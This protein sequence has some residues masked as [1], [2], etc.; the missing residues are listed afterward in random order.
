[1]KKYKGIIPGLLACIVIAIV[2][3]ILGKFVPQLGASTFAIV[4]GVICGNTIIGGKR[5]T[6]GVKFSEKVLLAWAI[7]LLGVILNLNEII[8]IGY[9]GV[10]F[11]VIQM[12]LTIIVTYFIGK[13]LGFGK[14]FTLLMC[15]GNAVCGSSAIAATEGVI[16]ADPKD[17]GISVAIV[18]LT[19]T[20]LMFVLPGI[21]YLI[22][23]N[24]VMKSSA[25]IGGIL[26]SVGQVVA[27]G[28]MISPA[29]SE[30][31]T[32][33]KIIRIIFL[34]VV[35]LVLAKVN[36]GSDKKE[37][38]HEEENIKK[39]K[40]SVPWFIYLFFG[41]TLLYTFGFIPKWLGNGVHQIGDILEIIALA[42]IGASVKFKD[43]LEQGPKAII[44]GGL[45]G[46]SQII[47]AL[48]LIF[49]LL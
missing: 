38:K 36:S 33:F 34:V 37:L 9:K 28:K 22:Y 7:G 17:K 49:I 47:F 2:S 24:Q 44:Y 23:G 41:L 13:K 15:A 19:G 1:M 29:V 20:I 5:F 39:S 48:V 46:V 43:L 14:K 21:T 40:V 10:L 3:K 11:V 16:D 6:A 4:L 42:A 35:V 25:M 45:V 31:A 12:T 30:M 26:Q 18:N 32:I 8:S 27:S